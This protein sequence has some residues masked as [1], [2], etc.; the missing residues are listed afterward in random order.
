MYGNDIFKNFS[1]ERLSK[2][3]RIFESLQVYSVFTFWESWDASIKNVL[4]FHL[5]P[6]LFPCP[7]LKKRHWGSNASKL[8]KYSIGK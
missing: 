4:R 1:L 7:G 5:Q 8:I 2:I 6:V 3:E